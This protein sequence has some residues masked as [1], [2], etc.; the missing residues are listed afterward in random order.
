MGPPDR[1]S[2]RP[3]PGPSRFQ[4]TDPVKRERQRQNLLR[5]ISPDAK[6]RQAQIR[7]LRPRHEHGA[8]SERLIGARRAELVTELEREFPGESRRVLLAQAH[9]L[10]VAEA[11]MRHSDE[12][13][14]VKDGRTGETYPVA[15][16]VEKSLSAFLNEEARIRQRAAERGAGNAESLDQYI[17]RVYG[18]ESGA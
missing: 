18:T 12:H 7:H 2:S 9:R 3:S 14:V 8:R 15:A 1:P 10:A 17:G 16:L 13:G 6:T 4:S 5:G 11:G